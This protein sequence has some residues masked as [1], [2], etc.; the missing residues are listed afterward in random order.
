[1]DADGRARGQ[2]RRADRDAV[3]PRTVQAAEVAQEQPP[4][5]RADLAVEAR[6]RRVVEHEIGRVVGADH[7]PLARRGEGRPRVR[8]GD[9]EQPEAL[10]ERMIPGAAL[11]GDR[12][13]LALAAHVDHYSRQRIILITLP[14][15]T[16]PARP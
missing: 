13:V 3:D 2:E 9:D 1:P 4:A 7:R 11:D 5:R 12:L 10:D 8:P 16:A 6:D 15:S 14:V